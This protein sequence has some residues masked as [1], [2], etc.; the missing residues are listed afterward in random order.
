MDNYDL[1]F[2]IRPED[3]HLKEDK[4]KHKS[5]E[6]EVEISFFELMGS[7]YLV[8]FNLFNTNLIMKM[9]NSKDIKL[10]DKTNIVFDLDKLKIFDKESGE[11]ILWEK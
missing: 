1:Y 5:K 4:V 10:G 9:S 2:G 11:N 8:H 3:I 6:M 7:E